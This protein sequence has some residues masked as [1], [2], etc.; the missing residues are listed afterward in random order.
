MDNMVKQVICIIQ[1]RMTST[2]L[3]GKALLPLGK[4]GKTITEHIYE[5]LSLS[6]CIDRVVFAIPDTPE[7]ETLNDFLTQRDIPVFRGSED[8]VLSRFYHCIQ[9]HPADIIVRATCDNPLVDWHHI[10]PMINIL[11][12]QHCD[13]VSSKG[14]SLGTGVEVCSATAL[15]KAYKE[16]TT[17]AEHEHVM[18]YLYLHPDLFKLGV[19]ENENKSHKS[20]R[21]TVDCLE[22]YELM[23]CIYNALHTGKPIPTEEAVRFLESH[24]EIAGI[25][26]N[27]Q[28][29]TI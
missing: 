11:N 6:E 16:A 10:K 26:Q 12:E 27:I 21:L 23:N 18:P 15:K 28:Q 25:N 29:K 7:N 17:S 22:D 24:P 1:N 14:F 5:R 8:D 4:G 13:Y 20:F 19:Y 2:R 3:P 9:A